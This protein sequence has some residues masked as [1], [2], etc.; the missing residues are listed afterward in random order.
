MHRQFRASVVEAV[1]LTEEIC[2]VGLKADDIGA[3]AVPGQFLHIRCGDANLLRRPISISDIRDGMMTI[4][5]Q[6]R[7]EG[8]KWLADR[9][10]GDVLDIL[11]PLGN[12]FDLGGR[13]II[14]VG[15][16]I[17]VPPMLFSA[18]AAAGRATALLGFRDKSCV[19][20]NDAFK[21]FCQNV[22]IATDD[23][24]CG[25][26]GPVTLPL[27]KLLETGEY[28][29]VLACGPRSMLRAVTELCIQA[30]VPCQVSMEERMGCGIGA[31]L[32]CACRTIKDGREEMRHVCKDGPVFPAS[33]VVW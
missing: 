25:V 12:G 17:G 10:A 5:F 31:C 3:S 27:K 23:G 28:D 15:G 1:K 14:L 21:S 2:S 11:G 26:Q 19:I 29:A 20:L 22:I 30:T 24:S 13:N 4:V 16:G 32:V 6:V 8:T 7:G 33:E 18:R 9:R